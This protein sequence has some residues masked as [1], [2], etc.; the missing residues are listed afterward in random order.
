MFYQGWDP[1]APFVATSSVEDF[2][3]VLA[4]RLLPHVHM[5][6]GLAADMMWVMK[7]ELEAP[8]AD[9]VERVLPS[10]L[11]SLWIDLRVIS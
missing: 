4:R 2:E 11:R 8:D 1:A 7:S 6:D 9:A 10:P 5:P 3:Q